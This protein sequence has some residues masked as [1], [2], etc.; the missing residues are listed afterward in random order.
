M[1]QKEELYLQ[2]IEK[3]TKGKEG[4]RGVDH[5]VKA[6]GTL[7]MAME[8]TR[9]DILG[10]VFMGAVSR[11]E[12]GQ[13]FTP[14]SVCDLMA[15]M[16]VEETH[17][18]IS[19]CDPAVG[20]GGTLLSASRKAPFGRFTGVDIDHRCVKMTAINLALYGLKGTVVHGDALS[21]ESW[22]AYE[23]GRPIRGIITELSAERREAILKNVQTAI[24]EKAEAEQTTETAPTDYQP[25]E[26]E[27]MMLF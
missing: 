12:N 6:F 11:G 26:G 5:I 10:D 9:R 23:I 13:F 21:L 19:I 20:S 27:Q 17:E 2:T 3:Y 25:S 14:H 8:E 22:S 16:T 1:G 4:N 15:D 7:V 24:V 18:T